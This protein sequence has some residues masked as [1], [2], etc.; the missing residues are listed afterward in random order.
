MEAIG[1]LAGGIAHDFNNILAAM[2]GYA[3]LALDDAPEG[4]VARSNLEQV[5]IAGSRAKELVRQILTFSRKTGQEQKPMEIAPIV[6]EA[7]KMLRSSIPT[8]IEIR[9]NIQ[10]DSSV[11]MANP[12]EIH[13]ILVN[14]CTNAAHAMGENGG[15]LEVSLT[16]VVIEPAIVTDFGTLQEGSYL[17]LSVKD[18]G[19]G[20]DREVMGRIFEPFFTT[21]TVEKG[22]GMGLSVV[23]GIIESYGGLITVDSKPGKG[24]TFNIFFPRIENSIVQPSEPSEIVHGQGELILLVDDEKPVVDMMTQ[25]LERLGYTVVAETSSTDALKTFQAE[26]DKFD[27]VITDYAMPNMTGKQLAKELVSIRP[28]I[29][30]IL[31]TGFSE[32][33]DS[34]EARSVGIKEFVTKPIAR[35]NIALIIRNVLDKKEITV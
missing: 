21:K 33:I 5:L 28:D 22:T 34:E 7:L 6:K 19:C 20:M 4:T 25:M 11:I 1:T 3:D 17:K 27:L 26:P 8:T 35:E 31:C 9:Q 13:Q 30:I 14:L 15:L 23:H 10:A 32:D 24:T 12:T 2:V 29:P 16:D 18:T